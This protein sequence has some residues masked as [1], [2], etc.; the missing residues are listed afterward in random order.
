M[1]GS[2]QKVPCL[3]L[4]AKPDYKKVTDRGKSKGSYRL[5]ALASQVGIHSAAQRTLL[6]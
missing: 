4:A 2:I 1:I 6:A 3:V 5:L